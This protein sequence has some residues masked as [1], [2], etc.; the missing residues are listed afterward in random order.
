[1]EKKIEVGS[2]RTF[3]LISLLLLTLNSFTAI[4]T[5]EELSRSTLWPEVQKLYYHPNEISCV[6][7]TA[8]GALLASSCRANAAKEAAIAIW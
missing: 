4:P 2:S 7:S 3:V 1:M 8:D 6:A 5:E